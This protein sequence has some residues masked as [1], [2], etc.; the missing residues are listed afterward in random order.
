MN[1]FRIPGLLQLVFGVSI[2]ASAHAQMTYPPTLINELGGQSISATTTKCAILIHGWNPDGN[3]NCYGGLEWSSLLNNVKA[4][5]NGSGWGVVAYDWH[6]DAAT[7]GIF[8]LLFTDYFNYGRASA[9]AYNAGA[10][11]FHL[12]NQL[13]ELAP[14]LREVHFIAHS[15]GSWA[16]RKAMEQLLALNPY[17]VVQVTLLDPFV[18]SP[19]DTGDYSDVAMGNAKSV[20]GNA[21]IQRLENY[22]ANDFL[23][24]GWNAY[25]FGSYTGPTY[26]TQEHFIWRGGIDINQRVDW[27]AV[28][29]NPPGPN[30]VTYFANYDWHSG[31]IQ[32]YSDCISADLFPNSIPSGLQ[33]AGCPFD[34]QQI[35]WKRSFYAWESLLP[36]ITIQP[37]NQS[38]QTG[39]S[40][41]FNVTANQTTAYE[42]YKVGGTYVESGSSL[43]LNNLSSANA[44][45]YV[46]RVSN[47]N[48][49][50]YSQSAT[51]TVGVAAPSAPATLSAVAISTSQINLTWS[52]TANETGFKIERRLGSSGAWSQI[53]TRSANVT[54]Y[55]D[56]GLAAGT[57]YSY[58]VRAYNAAGDSAYSAIA[59]ATTQ[60]SAGTTYTLTIASSNPSSGV[61]VW[62]C[63]ANGSCVSGTTPTN[64][65]FASGTAVGIACPDT[66]AG[67]LVFQKWQMDGN[68]LA[69]TS[70][71]AISMNSPHTVTAIFGA[72]PP[73]AKVLSSLTIEGSSSVDERTSAQYLAHAYYTD[74]SSAYVNAQWADDS[75]YASISSAGLLDTSAVTSDQNI[76]VQ[77]T[78][79]AGGVTKTATKGV[80]IR[81]TDAVPT[82]TLTLAA[83]HGYISVQPQMG[84]YPAGTEVRL[85]ASPDGDYVFD[86]WSGNAS[87][88]GPTVYITM[89]GNKFVTANFAADAS[90]GRLQVNLSPPQAVNE[91]AQWKYDNFTDWQD[92]GYI[93]DGVTPRINRYVQF[94]DIPGWITPDNFQASI[95]GG[96][97]TVTNATYQEIPG[98]V[99]VTIEPDAVATAGAHWRLDGGDWQ[100]SAA[101]I[102]GV[103]PG[104]H[105][106]E[107]QTIPD[108]TTPV[109]QP[110]TVQRGGNVIALGQ[111]SP[112]P[113]LALITFVSPKTGP[114]AGGTLLTIEGANFSANAAV[115]I[116]GRMASNVT[117]VSATRVTAVTPPSP[118]F[119]SAEIVVYT[120]TSSATNANAFAYGIS[121]GTNMTLITSSG[122]TYQAVACNNQ[123]LFIGQGTT[124]LVYD[125]ANPANPVFVSSVAVPGF[126][127]DI[128]L[129]GNYA[130]VAANDAGVHIVDISNPAAPRLRGFYDTT[131]VAYGVKVLASR[132]YVAAKSGGLL[133]LD[134]TNPDAPTFLS[135]LD[136][137]AF[138]FDV[139][140]KNTV[141]GLFAIVAAQDRMFIVDV[142]NPQSPSKLS[143]VAGSSA[144]P[145]WSVA[146]AG[147]LAFLGGSGNEADTVDISNLSSPVNRGHILTGWYVT[148]AATGNTVALAGY[149]QDAFQLVDVSG[150]TSTL[151]GHL[152]ISVFSMDSASGPYRMAIQNGVVWV[153]GG[154]AVFGVNISN[155]DAPQRIFRKDDQGGRFEKVASFGT[156]VV[157]ATIGK[158]FA[159][160]FSGS[161]LAPTAILSAQGGGNP[162]SVFFYGNTLFD[163]D[164]LFERFQLQSDGTLTPLASL[165]VSNAIPADAYYNGSRLLSVAQTWPGDAHAVITEHDPSGVNWILRQKQLSF[166]AGLGGVQIVGAQ[167]FF[168]LAHFDDSS[169]KWNLASYNWGASTPTWQISG[170]A[171]INALQL[172][173]NNRFLHVGERLK[174]RIYDLIDPA[175]PVC[176]STNATTSGISDILINGDEAYLA[177]YNQGVLVY[178]IGDKSHPRLIRSYD[179]PG[180][181]FSLAKIG[182]R[183]IVAD[184]QAGI[185]VLG[186]PD[187]VAPQV[188]ITAPVAL[189]QFQTTNSA[190]TLGGSAADDSGQINRV[191]WSNDRGGGGVA[192][193]TTDW[194]ATNVVLQP[195]T[196][197]ITATAYDAAGNSGADQIAVI[198]TQPD[199]TPPVIVITG[200]KPDSEFTVDTSAI[201]LSGSAADNQA[202]TNVT[203]SN[204]RGGSG[205]IALA[206]QNWSVTN[207]LLALGPNLIQVTA[208]DSSGNS[209][210]DTAVIFFAP[211]DTNAP[212]ISISFPTLNAV[213]ETELSTLD[214]S[215]TAADNVGVTEVKW[216]SSRGGQG[217]ANGVAPWS[218]N[219]I[220]LQPGLN[221]IE[222]TASDAAGNTATDALSVIYTPSPL[223]LNA[224]GLSNGIFRL[225]LTGPLGGSYVIE[226]SSDLVHWFPLSTNT[227]PAEGSVIISDPGASNQPVRFYRAASFT[228]ATSNLPTL[229]A[230]RLGSG[231]LLSWPTNF[232]GFTLETATNLPPTSWV[233]NS[234]PAAIVNGQNT[235]TNPIT[236]GKKFYRLKK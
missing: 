176:L 88:T 147:N 233:S 1:V 155:L 62:S 34:Y 232:T 166:I 220:P 102:A 169:G 180:Q 215:G 164:G 69:F 20:T 165:T 65:S 21:R 205:T 111:Y 87:G 158:V 146:L 130:I 188:F 195:G 89:D 121:R 175:N 223:R 3:I 118:V 153:A 5:L 50:L 107:F 134:V 66:L 171:D 183:L 234:I 25:P 77:A 214:L 30:S 122:G 156:N 226:A 78:F 2:Y 36:H 94:K 179:T 43:T 228:T 13:N 44:G 202:V 96:Q 144:G 99:Q 152:D 14:N 224:L 143:E 108:W 207:L 230:T 187:I 194:L 22:Y 139:A 182:D 91:G 113:G 117:F 210:F 203:W 8:G 74:S 41:T 9:A 101:S 168:Y 6:E 213:F 19:G 221:V 55:S 24:D 35:G 181:A 150:V 184:Y 11:G 95:F 191:I 135:S 16:A 157:G 46:V 126:I 129:N 4:R 73:P 85:V 161:A 219:G 193:G 227:I 59:S 173:H 208:T 136:L 23:I 201:T 167:E 60:P 83:S 131:G 106:V 51:L 142:S 170:L 10:H 80:T 12:A 81:N 127:Q 27:G 32:F 64:R 29:V 162:Y 222:V 61:S 115:S 128:A 38:G 178:D 37:A 15:A 204:N 209:A 185:Q 189:P 133:I 58:R 76:Q 105:Q 49:Q 159:F 90:Y 68:D 229:S 151:R 231:L 200:P 218:V 70:T 75:S 79:T 123:Y 120:G 84:S 177:A 93:I 97:T 211:R 235:V 39:G 138:T 206:G 104:A 54:S 124:F 154:A 114:I 100:A 196:N 40:A 26:N 57:A 71:T 56:T 174:Y 125:I 186:L 199:I 63:P 160:S 225:E 48:G 192:Q 18:P 31:P 7:G 198:S 141:A 92:S 17:V 109:T 110:V 149:A 98:T 236:G 145:N 28:L 163:I 86:H 197:I 45:S 116:G 72:T 112:P 119:G 212:S 137:G 82:Y 52:D 140:L 53:T 67:G 216:T 33:G 47:A 148:V 172:S 103:I 190:I 217:A 42:W 132:A